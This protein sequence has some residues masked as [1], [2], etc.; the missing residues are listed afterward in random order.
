MDHPVRRH[1]AFD[2]ELHGPIVRRIPKK[3]CHNSP[4]AFHDRERGGKDMT[5]NEDFPS[6]Y[7]AST[8]EAKWYAC[9]E[10]A[11]LFQPSN[12]PA[13][14]VYTL[15]IPPPNI[16]GSLHMGHALCYPIQDMLGRYR[17]LRGDAVL[18]L[19]G[20]DHAGIATQSV[21]D[22]MLRKEGTSA[23]AIGREA[24]EKRVWEWREES[25]G[26]ILRQLR[27]LGCAFD[28]TRERFTLDEGYADAVLQVFIEWAK[29][30]LIF[31]GKRVVNW[32]PKLQ[33]SVSDI[34][35]LRETRK[36]KLYH[37]RYPFAD[38]SGEV[39]IATTRPETMLADVA[40]A[41]HP[42]DARYEGLV[43]KRLT[44]PLSDRTIPLIADIYPDPAFGTG[45]VKITPAHDPNDYQVGVRAGLEMPVILD[46]TAKISQEG[47][48]L[49]LDRYEA[50]K[51]IV[52]DLET[53]GFLVKIEDHEIPIVISDRSGEVIEPLLSEQWFMDQAKL[54]PPVIEAVE[55][56][57]IRFHPARYDR[58]FTEWMGNLREWCLSRQ[59][60]WGHRI[61]VYYDEA[62]DW[63]AAMSW[64]DAQA[65]AGDKRIVR[66]DEDVLDTWFSS[67]LWPFATLGW[68]DETEDLQRHYP[69]SVLVTDRNIINLWVARMTMMGFDLMGAK[70]FSDVMIYATVMREDGRRMSKSLGTGI[71]PMEVIDTIGADALRWTLLS[72]T[73]EN[74]ELR[75]SER[76]TEEARNLANK[77]WNA[78]R[79]VLMNVAAMPEEPQSLDAVDE[80]LLSRLVKTERLVREA[81]DGY[82]LQGACA[83]LYRF[84]W[85]EV[86]DWYIEVSKS[87]LNDETQRATPQWV[88]LRVF[89]AFLKMLHPVMPHLTEELYSRLR[90]SEGLLM[91]QAWP[92][93]PAEFD[94]PESEATVERAFEA[95]RALRAL[96]AGLDL[97]AMKPIPLAYV[98]GELGGGE[99]IVRTQA[100]VQEL[101][102]GKP[103]EKAIATTA[104]GIDLYLPITGNVDAEKLLATIGRDLTK[105][106]ADI[107]KG[108]AQLGNPQFMER[109]KPEA[110]E[111]LNGTLEENRAKRARL[112]E[113]KALFE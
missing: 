101:R 99:A 12:D 82:D 45:A 61:P 34:E 105:T 43:G 72:Q 112:F 60:W 17:R 22:K 15:T 56:G 78:T 63:Y 69:T 83:A 108:E 11:G 19:P 54:A 102:R 91:A 90:G 97:A 107:A 110:V 89:D 103:E 28:W 25:G 3:P 87:R 48:Y 95:T 8:T 39:V 75:Y 98:E 47:P 100:W 1:L 18:I 53:G 71:D 70:P 88:L 92:T 7:D 46:K 94:R 4:I 49:G 40:V 73:G 16:T 96:R 51:R 57:E 37:V 59:L 38:G 64:D 65:Q 42:S 21:V 52:E 36:G 27:A 5:N 67:G 2:P 10:E 44:L 77:V 111:K 32:D 104:A 76:K 85:N 74:Q 84:F 13:K 31:R 24:F 6:R 79:F 58:I 86:C 55:R 80:W 35:T 33:T 62:G 106:E 113:R 93:L 50:R 68:P 81:Y 66:Q 20:Q 14:P 41:V 23:A 109:A 26:T 30:G 9:W 29:R